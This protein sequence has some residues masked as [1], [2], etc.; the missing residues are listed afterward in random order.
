MMKLREVLLRI[1]NAEDQKSKMMQAKQFWSKGLKNLLVIQYHPKY[2][3]NLPEGV[4][5]YSTTSNDI[6][7][8]QFFKIAETFVFA[9]NK[10]KIQAAF[11]KYIS[12]MEAEDAV[13]AIAVKDRQY[14]LGLT[15]ESLKILDAEVWSKVQEISSPVVE[16]EPEPQPTAPVVENPVEE[17]KVEPEAEKPKKLKLAATRQEL[18]KKVAAKGKG[19]V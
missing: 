8:E 7:L 3:F 12:S 2:R 16:K 14:D 6:S 5:P 1:K 11:I 10:P 9:T 17:K 19:A 4:P 15:L 18:A 13:I